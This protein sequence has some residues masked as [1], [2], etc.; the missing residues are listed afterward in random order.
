MYII[1]EKKNG[2]P[3]AKASV[4][5]TLEAAKEALGKWESYEKDKP[6]TERWE[7]RIFTPDAFRNAGGI[8]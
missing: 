2:R 7:Y 4:H 6:I 8:E 5:Q 3:W 1:G